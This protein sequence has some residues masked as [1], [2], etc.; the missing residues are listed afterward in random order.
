MTDQ[1]IGTRIKALRQERGLSQESLAQLFG[2]KDRQTVSAIETG[3]RSVTAAELLLAVEKLNAPIDYF[4]D[5]FRLDGEGRFSWRQSGVSGSQ[6][7]EYE[8]RAS[9]WVGAYRSLA[10]QLGRRAPLMRRALGLTKLSRFE[11]AMEAGERFAA[12]L[13]LGDVPAKRLAAVMQD[14][15]GILVLMVDACR[16]ISGAACRLPELDAVLTARGEVEGHR[17]IDLAHELF[18]ILTWDAMPPKHVEDVRDFGGNRVEQLAN[19]FAAA[20]LMP[21]A[22]LEPLGDCGPLEMDELID[23]LNATANELGVTSSA[24]RWR[25]VALGRL[26][27]ARA[28]AIP[29]SALRNNGRRDE[30][31]P[32]PAL[33]SRTFMEVIAAAIDRGHISVRRAAGLV[34]LP[35]EDL[36]ELF[37]AHG[38]DFTI[39]L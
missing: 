11:D 23:R 36:Q 24:L 6:L 2:F 19:N 22:A 7:A 34:G 14:E 20:V 10:A 26:T 29:E 37:T 39:N 31:A 13:E 12:E 15:L 3:V 32:P 1:I 27:R 28:Q 17:N 5:P 38:I 4:T 35:I 21:R 16:G 18:H 25:L 9:R 33:Y 30:M 8:R